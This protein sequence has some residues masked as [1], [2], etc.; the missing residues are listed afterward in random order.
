MRRV[1]EQVAELCV[2]E[3]RGK[4]VEVELDLPDAPVAIRG[5]RDQLASLGLHIAVNALRAIASTGRPGRLRIAARI[6]GDHA[7]LVLDNDGPPLT[8]SERKQLFTPFYSGDA[9][10]TGL[11]LAIAAR[12]ADQHGGSIDAENAGLG[13]R[14][15][16]RLPRLTA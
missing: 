11:G 12:V 14:F 10:G 4:R 5:D 8:E 7:L 13:V 6:D 9:Q 15:S 3:A 1:A 16:L 2:A